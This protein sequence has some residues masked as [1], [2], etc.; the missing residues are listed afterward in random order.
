MEEIEEKSPEE[1][2]DEDRVADLGRPRLGEDI[3]VACHIRE[4]MEFKVS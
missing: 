4:S 1:M 3:R 2:T